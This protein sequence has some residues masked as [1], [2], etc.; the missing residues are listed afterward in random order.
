MHNTTVLIVAKNAENTIKKAIN[1]AIY[2]N[3]KQKV[4][5]V[6]DFSDDNTVEQSESIKHPNL[7]IVRPE[8]NVIDGIGNARQTA[9]DN[10]T[11]PYGIWL[12]ADDEFL[13]NRVEKMEETLR[14]D[15]LD[16]LFDSAELFEGTTNEKIKD[17]II[18]QHLFQEDGE[19][20][21]FQR[22]FLPGPNWHF[23]K[24]EKAL[25]VGYDNGSMIA[26]DHDFNLRAIVKG[27]AFGF[28]KK[29]TYKQ[30]SFP[31]SFSR[32]IDKQLQRTK[33][34]VL[35]HDPDLVL[36]LLK[37]STIDIESQK[38][39]MINFFLYRSE[40][41]SAMNLLEDLDLS[42]KNNINWKMNFYKGTTALLLGDADKAKTNLIKCHECKE[43][44]E[45]LNNLGCVSLLLNESAKAKKFFEKATKIFPN[46]LDAIFNLKHL[47]Y[48]KIRITQFPL[49]HETSR[50]EYF[51]GRHNQ[52]N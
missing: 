5:L 7:T 22:N 16:I 21:L 6:D 40:F 28:S 23:F 14:A 10:L 11:T 52:K 8:A 33:N 24:T 27:L 15:D 44:P 20:F 42:S 48:S 47:D 18:P 34:A 38:E 29:I 50:S 35:K 1:S 37:K 26:E 31:S 3:P 45:T 13:P 41:K 32:D 39:I 25:E 51:M 9:L 4:L 30:K 46:Y 36:S 43:T 2:G 19:L 12:D 17:L 49:R